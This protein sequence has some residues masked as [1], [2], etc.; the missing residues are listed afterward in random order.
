[1][2]IKKSLLLLLVASCLMLFF[3]SCSRESNEERLLGTWKMVSLTRCAWNF[4]SDFSHWLYH[5]ETIFERFDYDY[6]QYEQMVSF[7]EAGI[8]KAHL[9]I[10]YNGSWQI[11]GDQLEI[12]V[13]SF[14]AHCFYDI[15]FINKDELN[16]TERIVETYVNNNGQTSSCD[17]TTYYISLKRIK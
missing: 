1:M 13:P 2:N 11:S 5:P 15:D 10:D 6:E 17:V 8:F 3:S 16:L 14:G 4:P 9:F 7:L 12:T